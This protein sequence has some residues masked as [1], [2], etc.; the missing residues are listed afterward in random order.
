M[1]IGVKGAIESGVRTEMNT[2]IAWL[3]ITIDFHVG[4]QFCAF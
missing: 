3:M 4:F 2:K 1:K